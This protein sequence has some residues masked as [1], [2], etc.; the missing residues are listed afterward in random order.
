MVEAMK[1]GEARVPRARTDPWLEGR[2]RASESLL[3]DACFLPAAASLARTFADQI[4]FWL[5]VTPAS[6]DLVY[7]TQPIKEGPDI[8]RSSPNLRFCEV[9]AKGALSWAGAS[10]P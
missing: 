4:P 5:H 2:V 1:C 8:T 6:S 9:W 10:Q 7:R 3:V